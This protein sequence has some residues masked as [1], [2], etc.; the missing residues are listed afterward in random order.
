LNAA[1]LGRRSKQFLAFGLAGRRTLLCFALTAGWPLPDNPN[2]GF[3]EE[4]R[5]EER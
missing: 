4:D 3:D 1:R 5:Q 2:D